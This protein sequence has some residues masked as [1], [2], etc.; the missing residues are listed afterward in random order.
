GLVRALGLA[1][2]ADDLVVAVVLPLGL[3]VPDLAVA[4]VDVVAPLAQ[5]GVGEALFARGDE[6]GVLAVGLAEQLVAELRVGLE[7]GLRVEPGLEPGLAIA[8]PAVARVD[9]VAQDRQFAQRLV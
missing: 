3:V 8:V 4:R 2:G 7:P 5:L 9:G 1:A 6:V